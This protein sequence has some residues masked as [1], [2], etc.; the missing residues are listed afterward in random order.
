MLARISEGFRL[1]LDVATVSPLDAKNCRRALC[2]ESKPHSNSL[3]QCERNAALITE[4]PRKPIRVH[5]TGDVQ[6]KGSLVPRPITDCSRQFADS[7]NSYIKCFSLSCSTHWTRRCR[8]VHFQ[9]LLY[10]CRLEIRLSRRV[11]IPAAPQLQG[12]CSG[13]GTEPKKFYVD[14]FLCFEFSCAP[15]ILHR[16][17]TAVTRIMHRECLSV[18]VYLGNFL[19][20]VDS[21]KSCAATHQ[22]LTNFL[23]CLGLSVN[24]DKMIT[25]T[26]RICFP[27]YTLDSKFQR[28][29]FSEGKVIALCTLA[30]QYALQTRLSK[31]GMQIILGQM[32]FAGRAVYG[33]RTYLRTP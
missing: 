21:A 17:S 2:S 24:W 26:T 9:L 12:F 6:K 15:S 25:P 13:Y 4:W 23:I 11:H 14:N 27:G 7:L 31:R 10:K 8:S 22:S 18:V 33:E 28:I 1:V 3:F 5:S 19:C 20:I 32:S 29:E 16:I 30:Q